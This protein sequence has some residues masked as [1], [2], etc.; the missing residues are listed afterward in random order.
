MTYPKH[1]ENQSKS[2]NKSLTH[3]TVRLFGVQ[4]LIDAVNGEVKFLSGVP[5]WPN[6]FVST[7]FAAS[8]VLSICVS[9]LV[10]PE[11]NE[12]GLPAS[13]PHVGQGTP[14]EISGVR[15]EIPIQIGYGELFHKTVQLCTFAEEI[16]RD[17]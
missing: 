1:P 6:V 17:A 2:Q 8:S 15:S 12:H 13:T 7:A 16:A 9:G 5:D 4:L 3:Q 14:S 11:C 10:P